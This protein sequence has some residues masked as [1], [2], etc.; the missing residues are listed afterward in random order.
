MPAML[1]WLLRLVLLVVVVA[2]AFTGRILWIGGVFRTIEPHFAG[3]C[4][5]VTGPVGAED[6][7]IH[8]KTGIAY[9]SASDRHAVLSGKPVPGAICSST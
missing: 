8:P 4:H 9:I 6:I 2:A 7:T 5:L 3:H 1:R